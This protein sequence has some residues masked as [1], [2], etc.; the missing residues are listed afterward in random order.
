MM[1]TLRPITM[2]NV[3]DIYKLKADKKLVASNAESLAE[4]YAFLNEFGPDLLL[5]R[6]VY[7]DELAVGF[8]MVDLGTDWGF[9]NGGEPYYNL[10]RLMIDENHQNKGYGRAAMEILIGELKSGIHGKARTFYSA[11][12][13][14]STVT[15]KFYG[16]FG[17]KPTGEM[18]GDETIIKMSW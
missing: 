4:A 1:I 10:W 13:P 18:D 8:L 14:A 11:T 7:K 2:E 5:V 15:P 16:S 17:M 6:G 3:W 9:D 12:A